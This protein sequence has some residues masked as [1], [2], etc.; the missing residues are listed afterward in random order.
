MVQGWKFPVHVFDLHPAY[1]APSNVLLPYDPNEQRQKPRKRLP[2]ACRA[3]GIE[4]WE[5]IDKDVIAKDIAEGRWR[6]YGKERVLEYCEEDVRMATD[7]A[8]TA[9][10]TSQLSAR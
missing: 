7:A 8:R 9:T 10:S 4:G 3:Y 1:L 2:D 6:K 5:R